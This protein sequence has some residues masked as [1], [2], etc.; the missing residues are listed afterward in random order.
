MTGQRKPVTF[1]IICLLLALV[2]PGSSP[3]LAQDEEATDEPMGWPRELD[4]ARG[5]ITVYQPQIESF[6]GD[7]L[8]ARAAISVEKKEDDPPVFGAVWLKA[9]MATDMDTR[10]VTLAS[11]EVPNAKFPN[12]SDED[13]QKLQTFL[14]AHRT[15]TTRRQQRNTNHHDEGTHHNVG[16]WS[17]QQRFQGDFLL[18]HDGRLVPFS[19]PGVKLTG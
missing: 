4:T 13:I 2:V 14:G 7:I 17:L 3:L 12:E 8:E 19:G 9:R 1:F 5:V 18:S 15:E 6:K 11:L 10:M 16:K